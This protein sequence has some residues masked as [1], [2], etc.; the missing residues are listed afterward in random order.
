MR[1]SFHVHLA[2]AEVALGNSDVAVQELQIAER[3]F[4]GDYDQ[5]FRVG[6]MAIAYAQVGQRD[7]VERMARLLADL[8]RESEVGD[9]VWAQVHIAL[10]DFDEAHRRLDAAMAQPSAF[11]N[12]TLSELKANSW[13]IQELD[14]A[15]FRQVLSGFWAIE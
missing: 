14:S 7:D 4:G 10:E 3:L 13:M 11:N 8:E 5:I 1:A 9:A 6:Q 12:T 2:Y 15:R